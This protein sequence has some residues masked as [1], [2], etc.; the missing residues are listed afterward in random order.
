LA[1][2]CVRE[3]SARD[4]PPEFRA[5]AKAIDDHLDV[6]QIHNALEFADVRDGADYMVGEVNPLAHLAIHAAVEDM[7]SQDPGLKE[8]L[9]KLILEG[10]SRHHGIHILSQGVGEYV[11]EVMGAV[12]GANPEKAKER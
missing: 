1:Y 11:L 4:L 9:E 10:T 8:A 2:E 5:M 3:G 7:L 6:P 12:E